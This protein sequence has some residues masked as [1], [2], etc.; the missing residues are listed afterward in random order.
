MEITW[1]WSLLGLLSVALFVAMN[2]LGRRAGTCP[3]LRA[4]V[5]LPSCCLER[6]CGSLHGF[7]DRFSPHHLFARRLWRADPQDHG[8]AKARWHG[9]RVLPLAS[10][11]SASR[12]PLRTMNFAPAGSGLVKV[13]L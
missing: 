6:N 10:F 3:P 7:R 8:T 11:H 13:F 4:D 1:L 2:G 12:Y 5:R 9:P